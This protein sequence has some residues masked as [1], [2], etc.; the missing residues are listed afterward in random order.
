MRAGKPDRIKFMQLLADQVKDC[1][2]DIAIEEADFGTVLL[3]GLEWPLIMT[4][5]TEQWDAYF[6]GWSTSYDPDPYSLW[7]SSNCVT[8]ELPDT[9]NYICFQN[10]RADELIEAGLKELDQAKRAEIYQEF[11]TIMADE[12]PYLWAWSDEAKEGLVHRH[13]R[14]ERVDRGAHDHADVVLRA[15]EDQ[16]RWRHDR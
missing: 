3:P 5:Q 4:G 14:R 13:Q 6:G 1:G 12:L 7:H 10:E 8:E 2:F 9:Y 15:R 16:R 11:E